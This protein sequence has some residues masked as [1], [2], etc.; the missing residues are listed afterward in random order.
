MYFE[1]FFLKIIFKFQDMASKNCVGVKIK[2]RSL[3]FDQNIKKIIINLLCRNIK[4]FQ[5]I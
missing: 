1:Y 5:L 2:K 3:Y 4:K